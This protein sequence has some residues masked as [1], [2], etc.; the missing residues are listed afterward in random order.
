MKCIFDLKGSM[1]G[2]ESKTKSGEVFKPTTTL[3]DI[4]LIKMSKKD[5]LLFNFRRSD[6][7]TIITAMKKDIKML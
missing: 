5:H 1:V 3:K 2:R 4:N 6:R 7:H